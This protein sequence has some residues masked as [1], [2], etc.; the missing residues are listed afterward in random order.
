MCKQVRAH[1][2]ARTPEEKGD[3]SFCK[4][5]GGGQPPEAKGV[6]GPIHPLPHSDEANQC[7]H[8]LGTHMG[9]CWGTEVGGQQGL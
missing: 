2:R 7:Q 9:G 5:L 3:H 8:S 4:Q 6:M 1:G